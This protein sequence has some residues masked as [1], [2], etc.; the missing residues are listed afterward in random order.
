MRRNGSIGCVPGILGTWQAAEALKIIL[1]LK[2]VTS[3]RLKIMDLL[4]LAEQ[5]IRFERNEEKVKEI[6]NRPLQVQES[7]CELKSGRFYLD[8]REPHEM[9]YATTLAI[10]RIPLNQLAMQHANIPKNQGVYV[11]CQSGLRSKTAIQLLKTE[12]GFNNLI[13]VDGG[14]QTLKI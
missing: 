12:F 6:L 5:E 8:V 9:P 14:I 3:G 1:G 11:F 7:H 10:L 13:N 2:T 4:T